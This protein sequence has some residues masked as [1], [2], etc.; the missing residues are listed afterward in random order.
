MSAP[1]PVPMVSSPY[2]PQFAIPDNCRHPLVETYISDLESGRVT[3]ETIQCHES[4]HVDDRGVKTM[5]EWGNVVNWDCVHTSPVHYV[6]RMLADFPIV[7]GITRGVKSDHE[8]H[9]HKEDECYFVIDGCGVTLCNG[10]Y[11]KLEKGHYFYI[12]GN[13]IHNTPIL[14]QG[15][16]VLFWFPNHA[17]FSR[18]RY[19]WKRDVAGNDEAL[20]RFETVDRIRSE[21]LRELT[22]SLM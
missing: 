8:P 19:Y 10:A 7:I 20:E 17:H 4:V 6:W 13:T 12:P 14:D 11:T 5:D 9:F 3:F 2:A 21:H 16:S 22:H 18:V 15:L 1:T